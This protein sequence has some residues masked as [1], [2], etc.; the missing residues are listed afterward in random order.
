MVA[1][2]RRLSVVIPVYEVE[3]YLTD[4]LDSI[5][6]QSYAGVEVIAVDDASS[7]KRSEILK[8]PEQ[9]ARGVQVLHSNHVGP[10]HAR[11]VGLEHASGE[12]VWFV[13]ADDVIPPGTLQAIADVIERNRPDVLLV[14]FE[15]LEPSGQTRASPV[16]DLLRQAPS[17]CFRLSEWPD[18]ISMTATVWSKV[19]RRDFLKESAISFPRGIHE[20]V[21]VSFAALLGARK[22]A[23]LSR[24]CYLYRQRPGSFMATAS[25]GHFDIFRSYQQVFE[26]A[27]K[28]QS[29]G[30]VSITGRVRT[31][32][33]DRAISHYTTNLDGHGGERV[34][35]ADRRQ[36]FTMMHD[37]FHA[38]RPTGYRR[39]HGLR[40]L[41]YWLIERNAYLA[42]SV[43]TPINDIRARMLQSTT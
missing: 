36:Y 21:P 13:D 39:P 4:C 14:G 1:A 43:L 6:E 37:D 17:G 34:P 7:D 2:T 15:Y 33:F 30:A 40:G 38:Y 31:A 9:A 12:Y 11:N 18:A 8:T 23:A 19:F 26:I 29:D 16:R 41:K 25:A 32:L 28:Q 3:D 35:T 5:L 20:D 24:V 10:G 22:I 42:Y 27:D